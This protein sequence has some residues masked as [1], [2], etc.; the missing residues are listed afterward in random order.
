VTPSNS[1]NSVEAEEG[2]AH[3][4]ARDPTM[5]QDTSFSCSQIPATLAKD[6]ANGDLVW[7]WDLD[8][9]QQLGTLRVVVRRIGNKSQR[10]GCKR[11][12]LISV[13]HDWIAFRQHREKLR[14][15]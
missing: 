15:L 12:V 8:G 9:Y 2:K 11:M 3:G 14:V 13:R 4:H 1:L 5:S 7:K 10:S 6:S